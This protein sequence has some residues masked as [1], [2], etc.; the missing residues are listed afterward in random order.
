[1]GL[2]YE[3]F[4]NEVFDKNGLLTKL[5]PRLTEDFN[6]AYDVVDVLGTEKP[7]KTA[8]MWCNDKGQERRFTFAD[9]KL[10]SDKTANVLRDAGIKKGDAVMLVLK[11]HWQFW[12]AMM[13]LCKIGA[14]VIPATHLLTE[15]DYVYRFN[16][17][18]VKAVIA[19]S[20]H[21]T[22]ESI[23]RAEKEAPSLKLKFIV[24][25]KRP[26]WNN[27]DSL[28]DAASDVFVKPTG[29]AMTKN[30][31]KML[32][33]FTSGTSGLPKMVWHD[34]TYPIGHIITARYW[35]NVVPDGLHF[36]VAD[37]GWG[38]AVWGKLY[39]QWL[40]EAGVFTYD[41]DKFSGHDVLHM[42]EKYRITTFCAPPTIY[43]FFIQEDLS[44][45]DLSSLTYATTAGE[46]LNPEVY[47]VFYRATGLKLM[48][49]F[50][51]TET[52]LSVCTLVGMQPKP[53][54]MG[55]PSP[56]YTV[57][58]FDETGKEAPAGVAG[59]IVIGTEK[60]KPAGM[61]GGYYRD[62]ARTDSVWHD[63]WYHTGDVAW[64]DEDGYFWYVGRTD[65]LIKSSGYR[66]GP[67]EIESVLME[68]PAVAE[69][70]I[71]GV[72][73]PVRGQVVKATIILAKGFTGSDA[74]VKE[75]Q[76]YVKKNT[77]P[78]KYPRIIEFVDEL[79][80]TISGKIRRVELRGE[81]N[82]STTPD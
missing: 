29:D 20:D 15:H 56:G 9:M 69:C 80:K 50:G 23:D 68:H 8:M 16:A 51:Q 17:A 26:G 61:F 53:G 37:T 70:A 73:D 54:S 48:E 81:K 67:F 5:E 74:L 47:N 12:S 14:L 27:F 78:Y 62:K 7:G 59:E 4:V 11:R 60:G 25:G 30:G 57:R 40:C 58:I 3:K 24:N 71:T 79:P 43:R 38:K 10:L 6:F 28:V 42:I 39:G 64:C 13:A 32:M 22:A 65:D 19:T 82:R 33:Y 52:T 66:I 55:K 34:F 72:P 2:L 31:D 75:L 36:T 35:H 76:V 41:F 18:S 46:A 21:D 49:G 63:N 77:A 45:F 1:M 44:K